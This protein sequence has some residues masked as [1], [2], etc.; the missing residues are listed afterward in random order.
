[1]CAKSGRSLDD[2]CHSDEGG[3][4]LYYTKRNVTPIEHRGMLQAALMLRAR[5]NAGLDLKIDLYPFWAIQAYLT[6]N[7]VINQAENERTENGGEESNDMALK[8]KGD[9][10]AFSAIYEFMQERG[11]REKE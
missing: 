5:Y 7:S 11:L 8:G 1:M 2:L 6:A 10:G 9:S 4:K 3:C